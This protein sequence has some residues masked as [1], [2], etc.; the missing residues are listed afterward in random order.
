MHLS[1]VLL[2]PTSTTATRISLAISDLLTVVIAS[3]SYLFEPLPS[4]ALENCRNNL[5]QTIVL[6]ILSFYAGK[7]QEL[8]LLVLRFHSDGMRFPSISSLKDQDSA[9]A[10]SQLCHNHASVVFASL[11]FIIFKRH[12]VDTHDLGHLVFHRYS[13]RR[14]I[15]VLLGAK[16]LL[17]SAFCRLGGFVWLS[18]A[19]SSLSLA[20]CFPFFSSAKYHP[21]LVSSGLGFFA[22]FVCS[23]RSCLLP[24]ATPTP[25]VRSLFCVCTFKILVQWL[26]ISIS[27]TVEIMIRLI[28]RHIY[29]TYC[30]LSIYYI[31]K[32]VFPWD[33]NT[34][35]GPLIRNHTLTTTSITTL[36]FRLSSLFSRT[37]FPPPPPITGP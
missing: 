25:S 20:F 31:S 36:A 3:P 5:L 12:S 16:R 22:L 35:S 17:E 13:D 4:P 10:I 28:L 37:H 21:S 24:S 32:I 33:I 23:V 34:T 9:S 2:C 11:L 7:W 29:G 18:A 19:A 14:T 26:C 27:S 1:N 8:I 15:S 6:L 30:L